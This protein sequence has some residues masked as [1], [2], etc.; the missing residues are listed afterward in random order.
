MKNKRDI[1]GCDSKVVL[2]IS[3]EQ[4]GIGQ[5]DLFSYLR[6][7]PLHLLSLSLQV[8]H[9]HTKLGPC[10]DQ[11]LI[12]STGALLCVLESLLHCSAAL[13]HGFEALLVHRLGDFFQVTSSLFGHALNLVFKL[14]ALEGL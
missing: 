4:F 11:G 8:L 14:V 10:A 9:G 3:I 7:C 12:K 5:R 13:L 2:I 6:G 1:I